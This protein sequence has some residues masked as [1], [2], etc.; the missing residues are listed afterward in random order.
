MPAE[1]PDIAV[2]DEDPVGL[3]LH[4]RI[5]ARKC[6]GAPPMRGGAAAVEQAG[7]GQDV[8]A[9]SRRWRRA[10]RAW[11]SRARS[12]RLLASSPRVRTPSP[13][14]TISVVIAP[15]GLKPRASNST[16]DELR[17]GPG[18]S[19]DHPDRRRLAGAARRD[20]EHRDRAGRIEQL[21]VRER[22][23]R[24]SWSA[25][26]ACPEMREICHFGQKRHHAQDAAVKRN[27]HIL[28]GSRCRHR[29]RS[30]LSCFRR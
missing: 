9:R 3:Q 1:R 8:G 6:L 14:A 28:E 19:R 11:P 12:Q 4:L 7:F 16:P 23:A 15:R 27:S 18:F 10:R 5:G 21:E 13:P 17:T 2:A 22:S 20:L 24:R 29:C 26:D 25:W 30:V